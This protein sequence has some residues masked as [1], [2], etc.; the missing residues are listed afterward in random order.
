MVLNPSDTS[1]LITTLVR[2]TLNIGL[3]SSRIKLFTAGLAI[4]SNC[5]IKRNE[6]GFKVSP[7]LF[8]RSR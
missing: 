6:S 5:L 8:L 4:L 2:A 7:Y 1:D 3:L